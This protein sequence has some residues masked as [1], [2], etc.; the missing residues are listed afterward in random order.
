MLVVINILELKSRSGLLQ[1]QILSSLE[2]R[3]LW[4]KETFT[5]KEFKVWQ[6][7]VGI[8]SSNASE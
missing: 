6:S 4:K 7:L 3:I 5:L 8:N 2:R 1:S